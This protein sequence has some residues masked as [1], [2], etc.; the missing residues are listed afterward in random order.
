M[1]QSFKICRLLFVQPHVKQ[2]LN[3]NKELTAYSEP[4]IQVR[5]LDAVSVKSNGLQLSAPTV[6]PQEKRIPSS[7]VYILELRT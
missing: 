3:G 7:V 5:S 6:S 1:K 2:I 4:C